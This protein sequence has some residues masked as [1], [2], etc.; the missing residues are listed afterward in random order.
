MRVSDLYEVGTDPNQ[1]LNF[2]RRVAVLA[3]APGPGSEP[4]ANPRKSR[5]ETR[6]TIPAKVGLFLIT[7]LIRR[8]KYQSEAAR[9]ARPGRPRH[10]QGLCRAAQELRPLPDVPVDPRASSFVDK[11][12]TA[13]LSRSY[14]AGA[15]TR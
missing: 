1:V 5:T 12:T 10:R 3:E 8:D 11:A 7:S 15:W 4:A 14:W 13:S 2:Y 6:I 9:P